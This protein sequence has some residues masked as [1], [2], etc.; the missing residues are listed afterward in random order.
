MGAAASAIEGQFSLA[1]PSGGLQ[2][3]SSVILS[4]DFCPQFPPLYPDAHRSVDHALD[5]FYS[6]EDFALEVADRLGAIVR[7]P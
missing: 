6:T 3:P 2:V 1:I 7:V 5:V 4:D